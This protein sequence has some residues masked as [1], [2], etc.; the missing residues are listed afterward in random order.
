MRTLLILIFLLLLAPLATRPDTNGSAQEDSFITASISRARPLAMG[1]A[2]HSLV[3]D[4]SAGLYNPGA[5]QLNNT[6]GE[7]SF[8]LFFNP[9]AP[10]LAMYDYAKYDSDFDRDDELTLTEGLIAASRV[11][12]GAVYTTPLWDFGV[13]FGEEILTA[14]ST[15]KVKNRVFSSERLAKSSFNSAFTNFKI[16]STVSIGMTGTLYNSRTGDSVVNKGGYSFGVLLKPNPRLNVGIVYHEIPEEFSEARFPLES[17]EN[18]TVT[19]G[20]SYYPDE[21]TVFSIDLRN[22]NKEDKLASRE[23]HAGLERCF[24]ERLALR[25]GYY[26]I[27]QTNNDVY[28]FGVGIL[29]LWGKI[30]KF[31]NS[32]RNDLFSYSFILEEN[33]QT[34][35]WHV[36]SLLLRH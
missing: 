16:A 31:V 15:L 25:A 17:I 8:R 19:S 32:S 26:R 35:R 12:K 28:S 21:K 29:P 7:N 10:A 18:K 27:K 30:S 36:F 14:N 1:G 22:L 3:D 34:R 5:F 13:N 6:R 9:V 11:L 23:I 20:V 33:G 24:G 2:Y 4:F